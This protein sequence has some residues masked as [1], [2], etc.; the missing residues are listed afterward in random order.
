MEGVVN[1]TVN[2][3]PV[4]L[5]DAEPIKNIRKSISEEDANTNLEKY[6]DLEIP[7]KMGYVNLVAEMDGKVVGYMFSTILNAG[8]GIKRSGWI[9]D[10]GIHP[11]QMGHGIGLKL[12]EEICQSY[13]ERGVEYIYSSVKW[14]STD[15]LS[16]F[17]KLGFGRSDFINLKKKL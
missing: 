9:I 7:D 1:S 14:D 10:L 16:F 12:A 17:K 5:E 2:I 3:R 8:F 4:T 11:D 13:K 6:F 15:M